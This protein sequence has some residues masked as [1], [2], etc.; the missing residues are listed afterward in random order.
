MSEPVYKLRSGIITSLDAAAQSVGY[1]GPVFVIAFVTT[2][3]AAGAAGFATP[4]AVFIG[5]IG[6]IAV[7]YVVALFAMRHRAAGS[8][9]TYLGK[10]FGP[11]FGFMGGWIYIFA[12][13]A[14][15]VVLFLVF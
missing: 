1:I 9:Y 7:G 2:Y 8:L 13:L 4:L 5:G 6:S 11:V 10:A 15:M 14:S 12:L 3:V